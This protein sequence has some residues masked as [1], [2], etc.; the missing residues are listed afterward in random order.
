MC[1]KFFFD[2]RNVLSENDG[3]KVLF[4]G[5]CGVF[6]LIWCML[7]LIYFNDSGMDNFGK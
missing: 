4:G 7:Y 6:L 2:C 5:F 1:K 3:L